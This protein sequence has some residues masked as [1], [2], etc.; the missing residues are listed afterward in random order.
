MSAMKK[1]QTCVPMTC[2]LAIVSILAVSLSHANAGQRRK[3]WE[4]GDIKIELNI[5][6]EQSNAI[7]KV[8]QTAQPNL[9]ALMDLLS[10]EE[11]SLSLLVDADHAQESIVTEQIDKVEAARGALSKERLLMIYRMGRE[12]S[13]EQR[14]E[15]RERIKQNRR[16]SRPSSQN[17]RERLRSPPD[18]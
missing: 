12:L 2:L 3:W 16:R 7:E 11:R 9:R 15:L 1:M 17:R 4:S 8:Y 18:R 13:I 10:S 14:T 6:D 5:T